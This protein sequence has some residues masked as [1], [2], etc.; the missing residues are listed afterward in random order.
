[1]KA[2]NQFIHANA[3]QLL[4]V[5]R[6]ELLS[7]VRAPSQFDYLRLLLRSFEDVPVHR[8]DYEE[9]AEIHNICRSK[10]IAGNSVDFLICAVS[11]RNGWPILT[12]DQDF[13]NYAVCVPIPI[14]ALNSS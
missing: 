6:Q 11:L 2:L 13:A 10:G 1:M 14:Y 12:L 9:A 5:V 7:G 4:G 8:E 3:A